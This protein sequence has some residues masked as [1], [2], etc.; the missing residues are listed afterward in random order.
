[1]ADRWCV[2]SKI[3]RWFPNFN[4]FCQ[5]T[6]FSKKKYSGVGEFP[7]DTPPPWIHQWERL[8]FNTW[9]FTYATVYSFGYIFNNG[10]RWSMEHIRHTFNLYTLTSVLSAYN[11]LNSLLWDITMHW[12]QTFSVMWMMGP[13]WAVS[14]ILGLTLW[15]YWDV[16]QP[17]LVH[18][19]MHEMF[20]T[21]LKCALQ[22]IYKVIPDA[23]I[24][25]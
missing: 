12:Y 11:Y 3:T 8:T 5:N 10:N 2:C 21:M 17:L 24:W 20:V 15:K 23:V 22:Y 18:D 19:F 7:K 14:Y 1:M 4:K 9:L 13:T 6:S 25:Q 16:E